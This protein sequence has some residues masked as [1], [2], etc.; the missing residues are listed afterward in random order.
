[1]VHNLP[2]LACSGPRAWEAIMESV[3]IGRYSVGFIA[4]VTIIA[5]V[6]HLS[7]R[8]AAWLHMIALYCLFGTTLIALHPVWTDSGTSG[9]CGFALR[10]SS[11]M[12]GAIALCPPLLELFLRLRNRQPA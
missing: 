1:M 6:L 3:R 5:V 9:D 12:F 4:S 10:D 8:T 7:A 11:Y 2:I